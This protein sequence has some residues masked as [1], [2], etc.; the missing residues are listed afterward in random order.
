MADAPNE[1]H[2]DEIREPADTEQPK[3]GV[4]SVFGVFPTP[5]GLETGDF[6]DLIEEAMSDHADE[7][8]RRMGEG[9]N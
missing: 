2:D 5:P 9:T 3:L 8:V 4:M 6:D 1:L 7:F